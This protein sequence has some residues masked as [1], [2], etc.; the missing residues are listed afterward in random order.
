MYLKI[1][2]TFKGLAVNAA[3]NTVA[4]AWE[5]NIAYSVT[6]QRLMTHGMQLQM[7]YIIH[8]LLAQRSTM[9]QGALKLT[10]F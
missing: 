9:H 8:A 1:K 5:K 2:P 6:H 4:F 7:I 3:L 10:W